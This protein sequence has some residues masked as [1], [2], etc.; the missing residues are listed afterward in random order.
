MTVL[1]FACW[2]KCSLAK[3]LK[4]AAIRNTAVPPQLD[5]SYNQALEIKDALGRSML[6]FAT[7]RG[8][9]SLMEYLLSHPRSQSLAQSDYTGQSLLHY[10]VV[11]R[12]VR[13]IDLVLGHGIDVNTRDNL[14]RTAMHHAAMRG[15]LAAVKQLLDVGGLGQLKYVDREG[16]TPLEVA[17]AARSTTVIECLTPLC[18]ERGV[19]MS[20]ECLSMGKIAVVPA[21]DGLR[22]AW[23]ESPYLLTLILVLI[24]FGIAL[25]NI[26]LENYKTLN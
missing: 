8:N 3:L 23:P 6:H 13:A 9:I 21:S 20:T 12:R 10:A 24:A 25:F 16:R 22:V 5:N 7:Q 15:N 14:D 18:R 4:P 19:M 17:T 1:H 11:S 2:S 26:R